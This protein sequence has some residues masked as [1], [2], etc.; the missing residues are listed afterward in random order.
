MIHINLYNDNLKQ[1]ILDLSF[2]DKI[3]QNDGIL[4]PESDYGFAEIYRMYDDI[5]VFLIPTYGGTLGFYKCFGRH[6]IDY[7]IQEL[8]EMN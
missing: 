5:L 3:D 7:L 2:S 8:K 1:S 6:Q 4:I